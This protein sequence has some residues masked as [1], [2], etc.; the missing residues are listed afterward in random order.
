MPLDPDPARLRW[1]SEFQNRDDYRI[2]VKH[3]PHNGPTGLKED[4][5]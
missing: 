1:F 2:P 5:D 4:D 3:R